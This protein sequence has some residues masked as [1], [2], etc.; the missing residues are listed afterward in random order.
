MKRLAAML[1]IICLTMTVLH[2]CGGGGG[3]GGGVTLVN[4]SNFQA[5]STVIGQPTFTTRTPLAPAANTVGTDYGNPVVL[6]GRL[7][8]PDYNNHRVLVFNSIPTGTNP[9]ADFALGQADL[10][11]IVS[12]AADDQMAGPQTARTYNGKLFIGDYTNQR[13]TI[14]NSAPTTTG[15][16]ADIVVG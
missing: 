12:G 4:L 9:S 1:F 11:S 14:W 16:P 15:I 2:A 13:I 7:Y 8:L 10:T 3:G 6:N 5:A